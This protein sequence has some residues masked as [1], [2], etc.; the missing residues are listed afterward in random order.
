MSQHKHTHTK[1]KNITTETTWQKDSVYG[2]SNLATQQVLVLNI[3]FLHA[4]S[5]HI[6]KH[7]WYAY[8]Y[9]YQKIARISWK[10]SRWFFF[11]RTLHFFP[12]FRALVF[13]VRQDGTII[14]ETSGTRP[15]VAF[16]DEDVR[17]V[18]LVRWAGFGLQGTKI[19]HLGKLGKY[20]QTWLFRGY[21]SSQDIYTHGFSYRNSM[22]AC[23]FSQDSCSMGSYLL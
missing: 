13:L 3:L 21:V 23:H 12:I 14:S 16:T 7:T 10:E 17:C 22:L 4:K 1:A 8:T 2:L 15:S 20:L 11:F 6:Y 5:M 9:I 19:S 18:P